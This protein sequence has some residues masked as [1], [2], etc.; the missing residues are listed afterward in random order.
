MSVIVLEKWPTLYCIQQTLV[1]LQRGSACTTLPVRIQATNSEEN[2]TTASTSG[3]TT[4]HVWITACIHFCIHTSRKHCALEHQA[5][6]NL[7]VTVQEL[8]CDG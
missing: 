8:D 4:S 5:L 6:A 2:S 3:Q 7:L 1:S